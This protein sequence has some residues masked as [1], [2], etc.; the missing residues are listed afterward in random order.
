MAQKKENITA[1]MDTEFER[2]L[3]QTNQLESFN[4]GEILC[5]RCHRQIT[6][7]NIGIMIPQE[8]GGEIKLEFICNSPECLTSK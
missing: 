4:N 1:M 5:S 6:I 8:N 3:I 7:D 2:L